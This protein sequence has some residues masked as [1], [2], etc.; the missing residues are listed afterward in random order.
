[1]A[2]REVKVLSID[3]EWE[4]P[5][6][7]GKYENWE[8]DGTIDGTKGPSRAILQVGSKNIAGLVKAG[9]TYIGQFFGKDEETGRWRVCFMAK[10]NPALKR[11]VHER[12]GDGGNNMGIA[13]GHAIN[14]AVSLFC[15][16]HPKQEP[17]FDKIKVYAERIMA[18]AA[19]MKHVETTNNEP[20][21]NALVIEIRAA[22]MD[23][24]ILDDVD[25]SDLREEDL[26]K[27]WMKIGDKGEFVHRLKDKL[28]LNE[29]PPDDED[30]P[31]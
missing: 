4:G 25:G 27:A 28:G 21:Q 5:I 11:D 17:D 19:E 18:L 14:N 8:A 31:F 30:I 6:L 29:P 23:A 7:N 20:M 12:G 22:L 13:V 26:V 1:M 9:D 2:K 10:D 16:Q 3:G 15:S 24:G